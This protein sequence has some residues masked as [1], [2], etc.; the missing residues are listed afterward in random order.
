M[1]SASKQSGRT[2][3][4]LNHTKTIVIRENTSFDLRSSK[5]LSNKFVKRSGLD[6]SPGTYRSFVNN[7]PNLLKRSKKCIMNEACSPYNNQNSKF[8]GGYAL[9]GFAFKSQILS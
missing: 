7:T 5:D 4:G 1:N 8:Q 3:I 6:Q 2:D 9:F